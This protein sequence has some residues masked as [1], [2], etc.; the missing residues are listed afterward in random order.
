MPKHKGVQK[1]RNKWYWYIDYRG[2]RYWSKGFNTAEQAARDRAKVKKQLFDGTYIE[3]N[4]LTLEEF[5]IQYLKDYALPSLRRSCCIQIETMARKNIIPYIGDIELQN[6]KPYHIERL[7]NKLL[8][9][10]SSIVTYNALA[11]LRKILNKAM[12]WDLLQ[13]NPGLKVDFPKKIEKEHPILTPKQLFDLVHALQGMEKYIVAVAG[14]TAMRRSEIF[15]L[16]W[17]DVDF[18]K[19]VIKISRQFYLREIHP[20]KTKSSKAII[21]IWHRLTTMLKEWKLQSRSELWIFVNKK[22]N[23]V[24]PEIWST[25]YWPKIRKEQDLPR[26]LRFHD[27]RHTFASILLSEGIAASDVQKLMR[28]SSYQTTVD[29]YRHLLPNQLE[30]ALQSL[31]SL[32]VEQNVER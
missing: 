16:Q 6:L 28:H 22:N 7:K 9:N 30:K 21:P 23:P 8:L 1:K 18:K 32:Y 15:G 29:I 13:Q 24:A 27:L 14:Y 10:Q 4:K 5:I 31:E 17:Q 11:T 25:Y 3:K 12:K 19:N 26:D 20:V 2:R